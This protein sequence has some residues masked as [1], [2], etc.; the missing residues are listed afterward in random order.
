MSQ[1]LSAIEV[2]PEYLHRLRC[3]LPELDTLF[4]GTET[5]GLVRG[6]SYFWTGTPGAGKSTLALQ[7]VDRLARAGERVLFNTGEESVFALKLRADRLGVGLDVEIDTIGDV[8]ELCA[9]IDRLACTIVVQDSLQKLRDRTIRGGR[10][11]V[12]IEASEKLRQHC[13]ARG[14]ILFG[15]GHC[16]KAGQFAGPQEVNHNFDA[17]M[18]MVASK[19]RRQ[20][21]LEKNRCG[22]AFVPVRYAMTSNGVSFR[23]QDCASSQRPTFTVHYRCDGPCQQTGS[24]VVD[25]GEAALAELR[26]RGWTVTEL[27]IGSAI[28]CPQCQPGTAL[29]LTPEPVA[30]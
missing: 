7:L 27:A 28:R 26:G 13:A 8:N 9:E 24:I 14:V 18:H 4:G 30:A 17:F 11:R 10:S 25:S 1:S 6:T 3:G 16:N 20:I 15:I 12:L 29:E 23:P 2:P 5:P 21:E 22:P 19:G